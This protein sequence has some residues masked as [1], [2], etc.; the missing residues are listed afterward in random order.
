MTINIES[1]KPLMKPGYLTK[2]GANGI[3][4]M[5]LATD[6]TKEILEEKVKK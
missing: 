3:D 6:Y 4:I 5:K 2:I 1:L